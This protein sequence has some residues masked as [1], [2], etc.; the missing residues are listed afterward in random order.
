[1]RDAEVGK[2]WLDGGLVSGHVFGGSGK[3][4]ILGGAAP[5]GSQSSRMN[6][7]PRLR[8]RPRTAPSALQIGIKWCQYPG[9]SGEV[10]NHF[11]QAPAWVHK[12]NPT[13]GETPCEFFEFLDGIL[14]SQ[15]KSYFGIGEVVI[16]AMP[17]LA[18]PPK[19]FLIAASIQFWTTPHLLDKRTNQRQSW[20]VEIALLLLISDHVVY[21]FHQ[22][23][24]AG[25][26]I[27]YTKLDVSI[28]E[29][30]FW[31]R[32]VFSCDGAL[33]FR[34]RGTTKR[35]TIGLAEEQGRI[36]RNVKRAYSSFSPHIER[37]PIWK[38]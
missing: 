26:N 1:L 2:A 28:R 13:P 20:I 24:V 22:P 19:L 16:T 27:G 32:C 15:A 14:L 29:N 31:Y 3:S 38:W 33:S 9:A 35:C 17:P 10:S 5:T 21:R 23:I 18:L 30:A 4:L 6:G 34:S 37:I 36:Y 12:P 25:G 7:A 11:V 8:P